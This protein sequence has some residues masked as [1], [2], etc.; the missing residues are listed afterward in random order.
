MGRRNDR[1][2]EDDAA[3][4]SGLNSSSV[5]PKFPRSRRSARSKERNVGP[6]MQNFWPVRPSKFNRF[7]YNGTRSNW[8]L[9]TSSRSTTLRPM[10]NATSSLQCLVQHK[11]AESRDLDTRSSTAVPRCSHCI[12]SAERRSGRQSSFDGS[13]LNEEVY[14]AQKTKPHRLPGSFVYDRAC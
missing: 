10:F 14:S 9:F 12:A 6:V 7:Q 11:A 3:A 2:W 1:I 8:Y 13:R 5:L 4:E